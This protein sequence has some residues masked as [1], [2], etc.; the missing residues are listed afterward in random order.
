MILNEV[1]TLAKKC[2][3]KTFLFKDDF[4]NAFDSLN[5]NYLVLIM[6]Q[7]GFVRNGFSR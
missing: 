2:K 1:C 5:W 7:M 6:S 3:N 4:K